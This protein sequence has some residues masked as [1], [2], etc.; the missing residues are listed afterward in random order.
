MLFLLLKDLE[1]NPD[2][3]EGEKGFFLLLAKVFFLTLR[4]Q[5]YVFVFAISSTLLFFWF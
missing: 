2:K 1:Q 3:K 4:K 5:K